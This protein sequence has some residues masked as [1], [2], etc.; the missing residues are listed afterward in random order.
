MHYFQLP[1]PLSL[2]HVGY[3]R[4]SQVLLPALVHGSLDRNLLG[5][6]L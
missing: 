3:T 5:M 6:K 2:E 1:I 4:A